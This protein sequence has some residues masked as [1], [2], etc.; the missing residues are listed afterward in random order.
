MT[1]LSVANSG[2]DVN[3]MLFLAQR[4][5]EVPSRILWQYRKSLL[6]LK[7]RKFYDVDCT[8]IK[9]IKNVIGIIQPIL[10][11]KS[12]KFFIRK[13]PT[14]PVI[15]P[16]GFGLTRHPKIKA[17]HN[18]VVFTSLGIEK[19]SSKNAT[20]YGGCRGFSAS[21]SKWS[22]QL[23]RKHA[24]NDLNHCFLVFISLIFHGTAFYFRARASS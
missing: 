21:E 2:H 11:Y 23:C 15:T 22:A 7:T 19:R 17:K 10:E 16:Y 5:W 13:F 20:K 14:R 24:K 4:T 18:N 3:Y 12:H 1:F 8:Y 9:P 6:S